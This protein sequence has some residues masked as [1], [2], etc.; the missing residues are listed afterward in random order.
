MKFEDNTKQENDL[1][2]VCIHEKW[3]TIT[4]FICVIAIS[5]GVFLLLR[6][7]ISL[8][9]LFHSFMQLQIINSTQTSITFISLKQQQQQ[10][11]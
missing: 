2:R 8:L 3:N 7:L 10:K 1:K 11:I 9:S 5:F 6:I 4:A